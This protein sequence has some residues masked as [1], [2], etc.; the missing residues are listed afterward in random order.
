VSKDE[1]LTWADFA[2][3]GGLPLLAVG[4]PSAP[5]L[6]GMADTMPGTFG[7]IKLVEYS[8]NLGQSWTP[9]T[10][11]WPVPNGMPMTMISAGGTIFIGSAYGI[12][13]QSAPGARWMPAGLGGG[14]LPVTSLLASGDRIFAAMGMMGGISV[15]TDKGTTWSQAN[16]GLP[17]IS[18]EGWGKGWSPASG[19]ALSGSSLF[20]MIA[21][22]STNTSYDFYRT[23]NSGQNWTQMDSMPLRL[24]A[25]RPTM[26]ASGKNL[27]VESYD[28]G[29]FV[30]PDSGKTWFEANQG[31]PGI[32]PD[33]TTKTSVHG[34][35]ASV[36]MSFSTSGN[37]PTFSGI[38]VFGQN[39]LIGCGNGVWV[40]KL[41]DFG[42][43]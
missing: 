7:E 38:Y 15:S 20:A 24:S 9:D 36:Q 14:F 21:H 37:G 11:G 30:S 42:I 26:V 10:L 2:P 18:Y 41:S 43:H 12:A 35:T 28:R 19:L 4:N 32:E 13:Q 25:F 23:T 22:D 29:I 1:G 5:V 17:S 40:R 34:N 33:T 6:L 8:T 27:F 39:L 3:N 16:N 31:L